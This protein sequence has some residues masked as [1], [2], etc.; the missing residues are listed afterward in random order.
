MK[1]GSNFIILSLIL[2]NI[3]VYG[4]IVAQASSIFDLNLGI[5][6]IPENKCVYEEKKPILSVSPTFKSYSAAIGSTQRSDFTLANSGNRPATGL[7]FNNFSTSAAFSVY[8]TTC[9]DALAAGAQCTATVQYTGTSGTIT[10]KFCIATNEVPD[11]CADVSGTGLSNQIVTVS[12][13]SV[14]GD[15][16]NIYDTITKG[17][18][19]KSPI[20]GHLIAYQFKSGAS[21]GTAPVAAIRCS[22]SI[23]LTAANEDTVAITTPNTVYRITLTVP[24]VVTTG[25]TVYCGVRNTKTTYTDRLSIQYANPGTYADGAEYQAASW[26]LTGISAYDLYFEGDFQ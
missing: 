25:Q 3:C 6:V 18:S 24:I 19:F 17:Q 21:L 16:G 14:T 5:G 22:T 23:D 8:S 9:G 2:F 26:S 7:A 13:T 20:S 4:V 11:L 12:N 1:L 15:L 10:D